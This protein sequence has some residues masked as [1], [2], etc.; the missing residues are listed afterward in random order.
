MQADRGTYE[1]TSSLSASDE[2]TLKKF[3]SNYSKKL[4]PIIIL[5]IIMN[6]CGWFVVGTEYRRKNLH[7]EISFER[8]PLRIVR[9]KNVI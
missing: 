1:E 2:N 8:Q 5:L 7:F 4:S 6:F 3:F 9:Y